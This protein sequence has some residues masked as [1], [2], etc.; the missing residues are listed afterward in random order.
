VKPE[1]AKLNAATEGN[2]TESVTEGNKASAAAL[3]FIKS[4][5]LKTIAA[6]PAEAQPEAKPFE[7]DPS[8]DDTVIT[9]EGGMYF[10]SDEGVLVYLKNVKVADP[11]FNL[12]GAEQLKVFFDKKP[13]KEGKAQAGPGNFGDVKKLVANGAVR[14]LQKGVGGKEPVEASGGLL[15]Y[16]IKSGEIIISE[17]FPWVRQGAFVARAKEP[18]LTLRLL[19]NGSFS[20]QGNWEMR[21][22]LNLKGN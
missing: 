17:R 19:N 2:L 15:T 8:P 11:R 6:E 14:I 1:V 18:N 13:E 16:N 3:V 20:T 5:E 7:V 10:D 4:S 21:G 22:N 9:C 12:S